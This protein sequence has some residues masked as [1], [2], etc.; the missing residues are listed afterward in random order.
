MIKFLHT[1]DLH[2]GK[3]LHDCSLIEDQR[4][5]LSQLEEILSGGGYGA[6]LIAGDVYDRSIPSP[7]AVS[8]FGSFLGSVKRRCPALQML[9]LP[10]NHD[11]PSRLGFGRELFRELGVHFVTDP[12]QSGEPVRFDQQGE[13]C[14]FFL[15]PFLNPGSLKTG[16]EP[17]APED[18]AEKA[19]EN[20]AER[21]AG[22][23][24]K[25]FTEE[26]ASGGSLIRSQVRLAREAASRLEA[27]RC[28]TGADYTVLAAH[29]FALGGL[30][31]ESERN[32]LGGA[33]QVDPGLFAGFD[34][35]ALGHLHRFQKAGANAWYSGS[36]LAYSFD[37]ADQEKVFL[38]VELSGAGSK[39]ENLPGE[40]QGSAEK[41]EVTPIPVSPLRRLRRLEGPFDFFYRDPGKDRILTEAEGD[42]LEVSLTDKILVENPLALLRRRFPYIMSIKQREAFAA[43][44]MMEPAVRRQG[45]RRGAS[46]DFA[47]FLADI[48]GQADPAKLELFRKLLQEL[49]FEEE[50][51]QKQADHSD[52]T[53]NMTGPS[54]RN[55]DTGGDGP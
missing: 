54:P 33:E 53:G 38:S 43:L 27:A 29:L 39:R 40:T 42:Y 20:D 22:I 48:Y 3:I 41:I 30:K 32:F 5:M 13:C 49:E 37:E 25:P 28:R 14:A 47:D 26:P 23:Q 31:S 7:E 2:L 12:E 1:A 4:H 21:G 51:P 18:S 44:S 10:G 35:V 45:E 6:L 15:L 19:P 17:E 11:S 34:Y 46:E 50:A 8:L 55:R 52:R 16:P 9:I 36:P 24:L